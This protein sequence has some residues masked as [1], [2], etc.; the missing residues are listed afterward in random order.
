MFYI[1]QIFAPVV[2]NQKIWFYNPQ[3]FNYC[4]KSEL[5]CIM[6]LIPL[7]IFFLFKYENILYYL[8]IFILFLIF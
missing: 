1:F 3:E 6:V 2:Q 8:S 4:N 7:H 5:F